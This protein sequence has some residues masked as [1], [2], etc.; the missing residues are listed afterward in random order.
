ML[1]LCVLS[2]DNTK[3]MWY[4]N[5]TVKIRHSSLNAKHAGMVECKTRS[6]QKALLKYA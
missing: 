4:T 1:S 6:S 2:I 5:S 3:L